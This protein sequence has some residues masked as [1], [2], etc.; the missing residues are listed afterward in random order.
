ME[1]QQYLGNSI[2]MQKFQLQDFND[3]ICG[4][5]YLYVLNELNELKDGNKF[6]DV[7]DLI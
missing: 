1:L 3:F 6:R 4:H 2:L 5:L 7:L